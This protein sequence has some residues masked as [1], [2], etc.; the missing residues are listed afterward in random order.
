MIGAI[1]KLWLY[2]NYLLNTYIAL[3][4]SN[5]CSFFQ[6]VSKMQRACHTRKASVRNIS[7]TCAQVRNFF[8]TF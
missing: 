7:R 3:I 5:Q 4:S 2:N 6:M 8:F 1:K